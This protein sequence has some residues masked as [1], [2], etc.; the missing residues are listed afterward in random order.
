LDSTRVKSII[1]ERR[2]LKWRKKLLS[3]LSMLRGTPS[4][5]Y[6]EEQILIRQKEIKALELTLEKIQENDD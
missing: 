3:G 4:I 2:Y 6:L 5:K 1:G